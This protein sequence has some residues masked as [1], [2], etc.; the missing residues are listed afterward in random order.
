MVE[1]LHVQLQIVSLLRL[2]QSLAI[3]DTLREPHSQLDG[4][5]CER[6]N[7]TRLCP[8]GLE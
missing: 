7:Q 3:C 6:K 1:T 2:I 8:W 4:S 5:I